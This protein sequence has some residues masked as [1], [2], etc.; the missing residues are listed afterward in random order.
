MWTWQ[1]RTGMLLQNGVFVAK[2]YSGK[3]VGKNNPGMQHVA[4]VGP[5]PVGNWK[6]LRVY[7]SAKVGPFA[8]VLDKVDATRGDDRDD[9]SGRGAFRIHGDSSS[10]FGNASNGC[11]ILPRAIRDKIWKSGDR[12]LQVVP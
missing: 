10:N 3:G 9:D 5:I 1:Q 7:D 4:G 2:G 12:D 6:M 11:I 8:I